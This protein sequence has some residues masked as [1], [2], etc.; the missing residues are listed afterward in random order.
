MRANVCVN[1]WRARAPAGVLTGWA[2]G[3]GGVRR[4]TDPVVAVRVVG[5]EATETAEFHRVSS[6]SRHAR[7]RRRENCAT[8]VE[9]SGISHID[10]PRSG[11]R[12]WNNPEKTLG[13]FHGTSTRSVAW[14]SCGVCLDQSEVVPF[15][16]T[17]EMSDLTITA[18]C[19]EVGDTAC[20]VFLTSLEHRV[21]E[22]GDLVSRRLV[23]AT[24]VEPRLAASRRSSESV[25]F[26]VKKC[27][28]SC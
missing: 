6:L 11:G 4:E 3:L 25:Q 15:G 2:D 23:G 19:F 10:P 14:G 26:Q 1:G 12:R 22:S 21:N 24:G 5:T 17:L 27:A 9:Q 28:I 8:V 7:A 13:L 16:L 18:F 20:H